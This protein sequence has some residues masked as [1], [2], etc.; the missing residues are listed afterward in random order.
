MSSLASFK[1][2][3]QTFNNYRFVILKLGYLNRFYFDF[4]TKQSILKFN[5]EP[6]TI[7]FILIL[8][9]LWYNAFKGLKSHGEQLLS[10]FKWGHSFYEVN[11]ELLD[12]YAACKDGAEVVAKQIEFLKKEKAERDSQ[13]NSGIHIYLY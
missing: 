11:Q 4:F 12:M 10:K 3:Y 6:F 13:D 7:L 1:I 9:L 8:I 2:Y 5:D